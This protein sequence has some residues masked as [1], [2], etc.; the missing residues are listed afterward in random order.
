MKALKRG[1]EVV[2]IAGDDRGKTGKI[3]RI[4]RD[5]GRVVIEG[6]AVAKKHMRKSQE[7]PNGV[8]FDKP[9]PIHR[10]N[11]ALKSTVDARAAR[12]NKNA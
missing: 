4:L 8:V 1:D 2:V 12:R 3:L 7:Y 6:V 10:S 5:K 11:V 9:M